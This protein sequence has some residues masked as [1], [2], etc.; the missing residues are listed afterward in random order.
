MTP[1]QK[2]LEMS[3]VL[4]QAVSGSM[5]ANMFEKMLFFWK[6][7]AMYEVVGVQF[8]IAMS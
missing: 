1:S 8:L 5:P 6:P 4:E 7:L 2:P 3:G